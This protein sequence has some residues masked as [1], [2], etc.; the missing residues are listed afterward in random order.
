MSFNILGFALATALTQN[1]ADRQKA[2]EI[3]MIGGVMGGSPLGLVL[4]TALAQQQAATQTGAPA[5]QAGAV[6]AGD[7]A[8]GNG[9]PTLVE[10]P[11]IRDEPTFDDAA[12]LL[13]GFGLTASDA[14]VISTRPVGTVVE[15]IPPAGALV[16]TGSKIEVAI[17]AGKEIPNVVNMQYEAAKETLERDGFTVGRWGEEGVVGTADVVLSQDPPGGS[18]ASAGDMVLLTA[19]SKPSVEKVEKVEKAE[20]VER[21]ERVE[22]TGAKSGARSNARSG[23]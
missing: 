1:V 12:E 2:L 15:S 7:G 21:V 14:K 18:Y 4:V 20:R 16:P 3:D 8:A 10:V 22:K 11:N 9:A 5:P 23:A 6:T 17:S 13:A 19:A